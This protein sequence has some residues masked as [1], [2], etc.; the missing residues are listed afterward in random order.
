L[1]IQNTFSWRFLRNVPYVCECE[2]DV[3]EVQP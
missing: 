3:S 1:L 2:R